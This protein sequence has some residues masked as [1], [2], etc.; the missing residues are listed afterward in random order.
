LENKLIRL[1]EITKDELKKADLANDYFHTQLAIKT[2]EYIAEKEKVN[3]D[4]VKASLLLH[5][6]SPRRAKNKKI[7]DYRNKSLKKGRE[8]LSNLN[9]SQEEIQMIL[10]CVESTYLGKE[11]VA[12]YKEAKVAHDANKLVT[13]GA[14]AIARAFTFGGCF[15]RPIY[16]PEKSLIT[17]KKDIEMYLTIEYNPYELEPDSISHFKTKLLKIKDKMLTNTGKEMAKKRH[18]FM[19]EF[20]HEFF[21]EI[22]INDGTKT[23]QRF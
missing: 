8:I 3:F 10:N 23:Q 1:E 2:A 5:H 20:L 16:D 17:S 4:I 19:I 7:S 22:N 9:F 12:K 11:A 18:E 21:D 15:G 13:I 14:L 6:I